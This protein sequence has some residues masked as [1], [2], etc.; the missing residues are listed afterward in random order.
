MWAYN[1]WAVPVHRWGHPGALSF[2]HISPQNIRRHLL[3]LRR[4]DSLPTEALV[5]RG[6]FIVLEFAVGALPAS[7]RRVARESPFCEAAR[8]SGTRR[9][10]FPAYVEDVVA[11]FAH[12]RELKKDLLHTSREHVKLTAN[13]GVYATYFLKRFAHCCAIGSID[14]DPVNDKESVF[15][16]A[17]ARSRATFVNRRTVKR[18]IVSTRHRQVSDSRPSASNRLGRQ[19]HLEMKQSA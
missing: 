1:L 2:P 9:C 4:I 12:E 6:Y 8:G 5:D 16:W 11:L 19:D 15:H 14:A 7:F 13:Q 18:R 3:L 17:G 10:L